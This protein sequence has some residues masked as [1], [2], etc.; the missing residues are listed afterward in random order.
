MDKLLSTMGRLLDNRTRVY[1][2]VHSASVLITWASFL[3]DS[4]GGMAL[5]ACV[6]VCVLYRWYHSADFIILTLRWLKPATVFQVSWWGWRK[7]NVLLYWSGK[8]FKVP[9]GWMRLKETWPLWVWQGRLKLCLS[10]SQ[11]CWHKTPGLGGAGESE[12]DQ[13][14]GALTMLVVLSDLHC[15]KPQYGILL[16]GEVHRLHVYGILY[17]V[18]GEDSFLDSSPS[19]RFEG[20]S[21]A[22]C[23]K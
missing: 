5:C 14:G 13:G 4:R 1:Q 10:L 9:T 19:S 12:L 8:W 3:M 16:L 2:Q 17:A 20:I 7:T 6:C 23:I 21:I 18:L 15:W 22:R 11:S